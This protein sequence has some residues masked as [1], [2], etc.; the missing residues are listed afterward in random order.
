MNFLF[1]PNGWADY[2]YWEENDKKTR[3]RIND[4]LKDIERNGTNFGIGKPEALAESLRGFYS[5]RIDDTNRLVYCV[6]DNSIC[7]ISCR[8][9]YDK[10][11]K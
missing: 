1:T 6:K 4:L 7:I 8:Y 11:S 2:L 10:Y 5:R 3:R 9:Y